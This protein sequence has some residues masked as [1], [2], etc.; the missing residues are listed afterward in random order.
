MRDNYIMRFKTS[1]PDGYGE[2]L[3][4][5]DCWQVIMFPF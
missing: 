2:M 3:Y 5:V 1:R 4:T